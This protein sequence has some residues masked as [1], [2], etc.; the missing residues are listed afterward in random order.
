MR[1]SRDL[2]RSLTTLKARYLVINFIGLAMIASVFVYAGV[3]EV[4]KWRMSPFAGFATLDPQTVAIIKYAFLALAAAQFG[5][6]KALQK[7]LPTRSV[8]N[9]SLS[10]IITFA[11]CESVAVLG[12]VLFLLAGQG[13]D[14][15]IFMVIS[16]GFFY[17]FFPKYEQW[18]QRVRDGSSPEKTGS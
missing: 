5:I 7:I 12:L 4:I 1:G 18:E 10:A 6:I 17:L 16:L 14:F 3:V 9:L 2:A 13:M 15:Y 11:L 8:E